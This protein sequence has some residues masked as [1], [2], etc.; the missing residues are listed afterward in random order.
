MKLFKYTALV[1]AL[2]A[3]FTSCN[4]DDSYAPGEASDGV[5]FPTDDALEVNLDRNLD[6]FE[7]IVSRLGQTAA[8]TY[9]LTGDA[10]PEVFTLP[11][12]V[13]FAEGE[14]STKVKVGYTGANMAM[15]KAYPVKLAFAP[16]T[17]ISTYGYE[18]LEM[19]VTY[20]APW[21]T[22]GKGTYHDLYVLP[23]YADVDP[24]KPFQWECELQQHEIDPTRYRWLHPY[25]EV[26]AK[27]C[28][29]SGLGELAPE[30]YDSKN[31]YNFE[32]ICKEG[33]D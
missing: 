1:L 4:D 9:Q 26:F 12:S 10:D 27:F 17:L 22:I 18:S 8:A 15:D 6:Y 33:K 16:G 11:T 29:S 3:G 13:T 14:N 21:K 30:E 31:Q 2:L 25:G 7:V 32:F 28:A 24:E 23:V 20:P 5:Y 19:A